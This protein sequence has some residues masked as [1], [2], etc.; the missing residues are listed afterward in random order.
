[1]KV[2]LLYFAKHT[3]IH[4]QQNKI[5]FV[6]FLVCDSRTV[7]TQLNG[8]KIFKNPIKIYCNLKKQSFQFVK[9]LCLLNSFLFLLVPM[10]T[11][12]TF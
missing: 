12:V 10:K 8:I 3:N 6:E 4:Q 11:F 5:I 1:M 7:K 2:A 9:F